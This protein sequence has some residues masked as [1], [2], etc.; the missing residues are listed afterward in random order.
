[1]IRLYRPTS[2]I[3]TRHISADRQGVPAA[4]MSDELPTRLW[5]IQR[6]NKTRT[7]RLATTPEALAT[8]SN[9]PS[10]DLYLWIT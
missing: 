1:M 7:A 4:T 3:Y 10:K 8:A 9:F 2:R 6:S 5:R